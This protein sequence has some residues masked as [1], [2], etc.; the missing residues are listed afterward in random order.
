MARYSWKDGL[1]FVDKSTGEPMA[2]PTRS[3]ICA[4]RVMS[5]IPEY[6]SPV[7]DHKMITSRS[8]RR[9]DLKRNN[10]VELPPREKSRGFKNPAFAAKYNLPLNAA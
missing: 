6:R 4:P 2:I 10:C 7:G 9:E 3:E 5:D 1:G 8:E